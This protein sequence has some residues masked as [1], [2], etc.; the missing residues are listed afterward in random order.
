MASLIWISLAKKNQ[1]FSDG[2]LKGWR[3]VLLFLIKEE[4]VS[5]FS[6]FQTPARPCCCLCHAFALF[7]CH[8]KDPFF[9]R[10]RHRSHFLS[11][12]L[13]HSLSFFLSGEMKGNLC[14]LMFWVF[15]LFCFYPALALDLFFF[16]T[17]WTPPPHFVA[18]DTYSKLHQMFG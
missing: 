17:M 13:S 2:K 6:E 15:C 10:G 12:P 1:R 8:S 3:F 14:S 9:Y 5:W 7:I 11:S 18:I 16:F 4:V